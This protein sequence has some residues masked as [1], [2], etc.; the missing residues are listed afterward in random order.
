MNVKV[1]RL[2]KAGTP[3]AWLNWQE[4]ATLVAKDLVIWSMG[5]TVY[6]IYGGVNNEG[7]RSRLELPSIV[8]CDGKI[9][10]KAFVQALPTVFY[11]PETSSSVCIVVRISRLP[12]YPVIMLFRRLEVAKTGGLTA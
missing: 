8:A 5:E 3:I 10:E 4:T 2:N 11:L 7:H 12:S 9:E 6:T 1:L